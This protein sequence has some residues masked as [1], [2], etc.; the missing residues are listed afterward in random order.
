MSEK[1]PVGKFL[2]GFVNSFEVKH[3][4]EYQKFVKI[5]ADAVS[6]IKKSRFKKSKILIKCEPF[7]NE[8]KKVRILLM[9]VI[10]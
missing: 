9:S 1:G 3:V 6:K 4:E 8:L 2:M 7:L 5:R 10:L